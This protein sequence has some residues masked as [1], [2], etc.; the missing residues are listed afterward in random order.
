MASKQT[1]R[2]FNREREE[3]YALERVKETERKRARLKGFK[4]ASPADLTEAVLGVRPNE[5]PNELDPRVIGRNRAE[6][7]RLH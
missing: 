6:R 7:R 3:H 1:L 2:R 5:P 4:V